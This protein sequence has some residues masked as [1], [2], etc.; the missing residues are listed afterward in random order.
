[1]AIRTDIRVLVVDDTAVSRQ[2]LGQMLDRMGITRVETCPGGEEALA[3]LARKPFD[4]V[5]ADLAMPGI[6]GVELLKRMNGIDSCRNTRFVLSSGTDVSDRF[7]EA[8]QCGLGGLLVKP[9]DIDH[10][11]ECVERAFGRI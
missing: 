10:L 7:D 3:A 8:R 4:L 1:M 2:I 9:F 6:D 5:I 11:L